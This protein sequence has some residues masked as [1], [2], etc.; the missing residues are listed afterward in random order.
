MRHADSVAEG[1]HP[2]LSAPVQR[3]LRRAVL[4][5]ATHEHRR[6]FAPLLHVGVPGGEVAVLGLSGGEHTDHGLRCDLVAALVRRA[7]RLG[8]PPLVWLTRSGGLDAE[9]VDL[10][11]LAAARAAY[12]E[13][14]LPLT[15]VVVTRQGWRDP[16]SG[17]TRTWQRLRER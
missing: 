4:D 12:A 5:H 13:A 1:L 7:L 6:V 16:R 15:M 8:P 3:A 11:W 10:A 9:D 14:G 2:P 17:A